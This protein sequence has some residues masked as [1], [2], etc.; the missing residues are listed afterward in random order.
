MSD[1]PTGKTK[2][3]VTEEELVRK[4]ARLRPWDHESRESMRE[5]LKR[6]PRIV[7]AQDDL[8]R[9]ERGVA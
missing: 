8:R 5:W 3:L 6:K 4:V 9:D 7:E 1:R 2:Y